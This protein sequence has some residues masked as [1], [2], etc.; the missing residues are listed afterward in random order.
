MSGFSL[1]SL[2]KRVVQLTKKNPAQNHHTLFVPTTTDMDPSSQHPSDNEADSS[3][4]QQFDQQQQSS[5]S[6]SAGAPET[7]MEVERQL[8]NRLAQR[9]HQERKRQRI[10]D[11]EQQVYDLEQQ[12]AQFGRVVS[13]A[14]SHS[15]ATPRRNPGFNYPTFPHGN[16]KELPVPAEK[17]Q[18][19]Q[20][21]PDVRRTVQNRLAQR[22]SRQRKKERI[23]ILEAR[24]EELLTDDNG[25]YF[26][27]PPQSQ[28]VAIPPQQPML[29]PQQ[30]FGRIITPPEDERVRQTELRLRELEAEN[31]RLRVLANQA[32]RSVERASTSAQSS[33]TNSPVSSHEGLVYLPPIRSL[34]TPGQ[35]APAAGPSIPQ[36]HQQPIVQQQ[37]QQTYL[38]QQ[39]ASNE[40]HYQHQ[41]YQRSQQQFSTVT[42]YI[43]QQQPI[44]YYQ[45]Q[46]PVPQQQQQQQ[47]PPRAYNTNNYYDPNA[48]PVQ[49]GFRQQ[50][51]P[52]QLNQQV[53]QQLQQQRPHFYPQQVYLN[54]DLLRQQQQQQQQQQSRRS[55]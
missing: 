25:Q 36:V 28:V 43:A 15:P 21:P 48:Y 49:Q 24:L 16:M 40:Q 32:E 35:A 53:P 20:L 3:Q 13:T 12:R 5:A 10:Q 41:Q 4:Q 27:A 2:E 33:V 1:Q 29:I 46:H 47:L 54:E 22:A 18:I 17:D 34:L 38:T 52:S 55:D 14:A 31:A 51:P 37:Q 45:Q 50:I 44:G 6:T 11:L 8:Q 30:F 42:P 7:S 9:Q 26:Q 23:K 19:K 39:Y